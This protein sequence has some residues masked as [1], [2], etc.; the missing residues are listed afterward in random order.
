MKF[1]LYSDGAELFTSQQPFE[2]RE[3]KLN[4]MVSKRITGVENAP[5]KPFFGPPPEYPSSLRRAG[6]KGKAV[7]TVRIT[8]Y[9]SV[10]DPAVESA[11]DQAFG[12]A[13]VEAVRQWRFLPKVVAGV[14][15][16][17]KASVPFDF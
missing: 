8:R 16:E 5:P 14:P 6:V 17:T 13:A 4:E 7:V 2:F 12:Q 11:T 9:G 3:A 15:V 1:H 10:T